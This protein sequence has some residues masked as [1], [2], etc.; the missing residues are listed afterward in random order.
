MATVPTIRGQINS[1][2]EMRRAG[3]KFSGAAKCKACDAPVEWWLTNKGNKLPFNPIADDE[4]QTE[5]H[6]QTCPSADSFRKRNRETKGPAE[7]PKSYTPA[8]SSADALAAMQ[9]EVQ[10]LCGKYRLR[11]AVLV[12]E[13]GCVHCYRLGIPPEDLRSEITTAANQ[14]RDDA[15]KAGH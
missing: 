9:R 2:Y 13:N 3:Y 4:C 12:H 14:V 6:W 1:R 10:Q 15:M 5:T 7:T 8:T 11:A